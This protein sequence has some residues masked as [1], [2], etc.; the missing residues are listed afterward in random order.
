[1]WTLIG[2]ARLDEALEES[3][4]VIL[5][6]PALNMLP[7]MRPRWLTMIGKPAGETRENKVESPES[8]RSRRLLKLRRIPV[9]CP[10]LAERK[11]R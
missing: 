2:V 8:R 5:F 6:I 7:T 1:L 9:G 10:E 11:G 4:P 3:P